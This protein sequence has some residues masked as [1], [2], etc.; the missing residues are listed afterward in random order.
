MVTFVFRRSV[1]AVVLLF[2]ASLII[3]Y[4]MRLAPGNAGDVLLNPL[5]K[6]GLIEGLR[7]KLFLD[8]PLW[9]QYL[10]FIHNL[11]TGHPGVSLFSGEPIT[12]IIR[13]SGLNT[14]KLGAAAAIL[15]YATA[16]PLGVLAAWKRNT[17]WDQ[18]TMLLAVL[19]MGIPNFFLAILLIQFFGIWLKWLPVAGS[20]DLS[21]I[22]LPAVVLAAEAMAVNL[23]LVRSSVLEELSRDYV[24][25]LYAKGLKEWRIM[26]VHALR[27]AL[28]PV[29]ALAGI[30]LRT[31]LGYTLIVEV[32]FRWPGL[33]ATL[34]SAVLQRDYSVA[35]VLAMLLTF[36]VI[37]LNLLADV[38]QQLV[39]PRVRERAHSA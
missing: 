21:N 18:G 5:N 13:Q 22:V 9:E 33:G 32:I 31:L 39:D 1:Y 11:F 10:I 7:H 19:G 29:I 28:P 4:G 23:R 14:L 15:T 8:R 27:N 2:I 17:P 12:N 20:D 37:I 16:I 25:T 34:V 24:R 6:I 30:M 38:G 35:Q 36:A 26:W 3:F